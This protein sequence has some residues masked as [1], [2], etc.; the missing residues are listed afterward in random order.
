MISKPLL[1]FNRGEIEHSSDSNSSGEQWTQ[2]KYIDPVTNAHFDYFLL[3]EQII[4]MK[5]MRRVIDYKLG[6]EVSDSEDTYA[7][8]RS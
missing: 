1:P 2:F 3:C 6:L 5:Q 8:L 7:F 4:L